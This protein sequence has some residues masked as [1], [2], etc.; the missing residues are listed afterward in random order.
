MDYVSSF[1]L[2]PDLARL[3]LPWETWGDLE[4]FG[5]WRTWRDL[6]E[7]GGTC[8]TWGDLGNLAGLGELSGTWPDFGAVRDQAWLPGGHCFSS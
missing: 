5:I 6:G 3:G 7:L 8:G 1:K 2:A 4:G